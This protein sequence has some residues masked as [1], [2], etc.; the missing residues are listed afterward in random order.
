MSPSDPPASLARRIT[1]A[2]VLAGAGGLLF[3]ALDRPGSATVLVVDAA[4][5]A[6]STSPSSPTVPST[7]PASPTRPSTAVPS[8]PTTRAPSPSV[9]STT[10]PPAATPSTAT[11]TEPTT[12]RTGPSVATRFGPVQVAAVVDAD[13][14]L[15]DV[16]A[17]AYP[18]ADRKSSQIN[19]QAIPTLRRQALAAGGARFQGVSG[20]TVTSVAYQQSL[21]A[22]LDA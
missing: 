6:T 7:T 13:G 3:A 9:P 8:P 1:P 12:T 19:A 22:A 15:C 11:C 18:D 4:P 10:A 5:A 17:L 20:A 21:Q 16:Q 14:T 2:I